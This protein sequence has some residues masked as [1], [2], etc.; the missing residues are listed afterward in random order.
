MMVKTLGPQPVRKFHSP[1]IFEPS[2]SQINPGIVEEFSN[3]QN[4][5]KNY[6][7][8]LL[9]PAL[10]KITIASPVSTILTY[11]LSDALKIIAVH[12]QRHLNQA[13]TVL[14]HQ[15]FPK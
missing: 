6:F 9:Q 14:N 11:P 5:L 2:S 15:N 4:K 7:T 3:H 8:K 13:I 10:A 12:E 1:R